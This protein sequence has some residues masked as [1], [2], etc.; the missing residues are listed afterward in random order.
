MKEKKHSANSM[1]DRIADT[2]GKQQRRIAFFTLID[3]CSKCNV[4]LERLISINQKMDIY[5]VDSDAK[6]EKIRRWAKA[7][8]IPLDRVADRQI[9]LNHN[10]FPSVTKNTQLPASVSIN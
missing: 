1:L 9:T 4:E 6:D 3:N 8:K 10:K 7:M 5:L 2:A